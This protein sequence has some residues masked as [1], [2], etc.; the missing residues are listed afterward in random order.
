MT[1]IELDEMIIGEGSSLILHDQTDR[2]PN[3]GK[4]N[5]AKRE[6]PCGTIGFLDWGL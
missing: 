1:A 4:Q 3:A 5:N 2:I 6:G